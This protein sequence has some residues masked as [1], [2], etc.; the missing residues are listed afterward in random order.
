MSF[1]RDV[2][3][4]EKFHAGDLWDKIKADP[5]RMLLGAVDPWST[6]LWNHTGVGKDWE[7]LVDQMGGAY[8]G[9]TLTLGDTGEG[10]YGRAQA[11][12]VPTAAGSQMHDVAHLI[13][14]M[15]AGGYGAGK[16]GATQIGGK[17]GL[18]N[19]GGAASMPKGGILDSSGYVIPGTEST[20]PTGWLRTLTA[21]QRPGGG[22]S[23]A[24]PPFNPNA[25]MPS[26]PMTPGVMTGPGGFGGIGGQIQLPNTSPTASAAPQRTPPPWL[27]KLSG[28]VSKMGNAFS[29]PDSPYLT[30]EENAARRQ[31][32]QSMMAAALMQMAAPRPE[33]TGS[34][35]ADFG[36]AMMAGQQSS[37][38]FTEDAMRA[39]LAQSQMQAQQD[40]SQGV[41]PGPSD[42]Q[43][44]K[45]LGYPLTPDGF[46]SYNADQGQPGG[47]AADALA[48]IQAQ[49]AVDSRRDQI[50]R[51][52][53]ADEVASREEG[54][55]HTQ[56]RNTLSSG[57]QQT[58][59]LAELTDKLEGTF[60]EAG[61]PASTWRRT[62]ASLIAGAGAALGMD[63]REL[64]GNI[65]NFDKLKKG[66]SDQLI[67]L[68]STGE[69]GQGTNNKLQAFQNALATTETSPGA[70]MSIQAGIAQTL[71][72]EADAQ[73]IEIRGRDD[74][75]A[76]IDRWRHYESEQGEAV[77]DAPA[78]ATRVRNIGKMT[79]EQ[80]RDL[81]SEADKLPAEVLEAAA[82][83]WDELNAR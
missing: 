71:L 38:Q 81:A 66:L 72:D 46:K 33:A 39:K 26:S 5:K 47:S 76:K 13:S 64:E 73:G 79:A 75:E 30:P 82:K 23:W 32:Q 44:M 55:K 3:G 7:P 78:I 40:Q 27:Q 80:L 83:R 56:L 17:L 60:L 37:D 21:M 18:G 25:P 34:P 11:A 10:V 16:L 1:I 14:S 51:D 15:F 35:M 54:I 70:I 4:F 6:K 65:A 42:I 9:N 52:R 68:M 67:N 57:I 77:V 29:S 24:T 20:A 74:I 36:T 53:R 2:L 8:G 19:S 31:Q 61:M 69:L 41:T 43:A 45:A 22:P 12:G 49:L 28:G 59:D 50:A 48:A 62:G 58:S 63:T